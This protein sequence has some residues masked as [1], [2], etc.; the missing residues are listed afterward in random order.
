MTLISTRIDLLPI[1]KVAKK[2]GSQELITKHLKQHQGVLLME[3]KKRAPVDTGAYKKSWKKGRITR[4]SAHVETPKKKLYKMLEFTGAKP[5]KI[6]ARRVK[7]LHWVDKQTG[8]DMFRKEVNHPGFN[9]I[10]HAR[11]AARKV[12]EQ[13]AK[14]VI[15]ETER[16][17][18]G[19]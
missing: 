5:H 12:S 18:K 14:A 15:K 17:L 9:P 13:T 6:R 7:Y 8:K 11:P 3:V 10:P 4:Q 2:L 1:Y 19:G 16:I